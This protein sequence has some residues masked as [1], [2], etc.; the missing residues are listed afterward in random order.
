MAA[1]IRQ[2]RP[3]VVGGS[4]PDS[5][6]ATATAGN[7]TLRQRLAPR[8]EN[9]PPRVHCSAHLSPEDAARRWRLLPDCA[10]SRAA[11]ADPWTIEQIMRYQGNVENF[12]GTVKVPIGLAGPL[13]VNGLFAHGD[14]YIP[15]A[16]TEATLVASYSRGAQLISNSGGCSAMLVNE[17]VGRAPGFVFRNLEECGRFVTW[18]LSHMEV[19][20]RVAEGTTRHGKLVD[21]RVTIE[22]NHVYLHFEYLTGDAAGQNMVTIAT[23]AI[24]AYITEESPVRSQYYFLEANLS[25]DKKASAQ[26]FGSVRGKKV[27]AEVNLPADL[28]RRWLRTTPERMADYWRMGA[29]GGI[30]S[31]TIGAQGH[32]ANGLTALYIACGQDAACVAESAVGVTRFEV[33]PEGALYATVTLPN[34]IVGTVGGGTRLPSQH[35]CLDI[36]GLAG[37]G[38]AQALAEVCAALCLAGEL[39][40]VGALCAGSFARAH[41]CLARATAGST[42]AEGAARE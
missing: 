23:E 33:T 29:M 41:R 30:L 34:L 35:A 5:P 37:P 13:R 18:A 39:S 6:D 3:S 11:L 24:C 38:N 16:T 17:R 4:A 7:D 1:S 22:G 25:G 14:Y 15:L 10:D 20:R 19:F 2:S 28:V 42:G 31:G 36:L 9:L 32:F 40:L 26:S 8:R 27:T 21:M 12:I